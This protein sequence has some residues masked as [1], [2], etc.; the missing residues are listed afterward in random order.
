MISISTKTNRICAANYYMYVRL[1]LLN[2]LRRV[3]LQ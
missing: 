3:V 2:F 1:V